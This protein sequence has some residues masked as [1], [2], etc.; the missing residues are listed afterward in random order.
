MLDSSLFPRRLFITVIVAFSLSSSLG[1]GQTC[2]VVPYPTGELAPGRVR[3]APGL[4]FF[5]AIDYNSQ[6]DFYLVSY[7]A[8]EARAL[9]LNS[10]GSV[11]P[12]IL[13]GPNN[14]VQDV[15][16]AYNPDRNE[17]LA[18]WRY[19]SPT[20]L[21]GR[22]L[23]GN[24][25]PLG[26]PFFMGIA[27]ESRIAYNPQNQV[28]LVAYTGIGVGTKYRMVAGD[29]T[30]VN[31]L[32]AE[33]V[34]D[35]TGFSGRVA[36]G[37]AANQ[38]LIVFVKDFAAPTR[39][40]VWGRIVSG[41]GGSIG[42][43]IGIGGGTE[44]Q[45]IPEV[46]YAPT[47]DQF[48]VSFEDWSVGGYPD[49]RFHYVTSGGSV[50]ARHNLSSSGGVWDNPGPITFN[51]STGK[52]VA[53]YFA[54]VYGYFR[55][56]TPGTAQFSPVCYYSYLNAYPLGIAARPDPADPQAAVVFRN[57]YGDDG[58][59]VSIL[60]LPPPPPS[61]SSTVMPDGFFQQ[62]YSQQVPVVGGTHPLSFQ[63]L[64]GSLPP[65][66]SGPN[67]STG[68]VSGTP[69]SMGTFGPFRVRVTDNQARSAEADLTMS[70]KLAAPTALSPNGDIANL[71]PTFTWTAVAGATS[72]NIEVENLTDGGTINIT[73]VIGTS[74]S[75][76]SNLPANKNFRWRAQASNGASV[77]PFSGY[78]SFRTDLTS[79]SGIVLS[80]AVPSTFA[81][82]TG[83]TA[84]ASSGD[85]NSANSKEMAVDG[86]TSTLWSTP[87]RPAL[88]IEF[89]TLD[90]GASKTFSHVRMLSRDVVPELF[91]KDFQ[92]QFSNDNVN[93]TTGATVTNFSTPASTWSNFPL[94]TTQARYLRIWITKPSQY[95]ANNLFYA[96]IVEIE[97]SLA[98]SAAGSI[99]VTWAAPGDDGAT[100]TAASYDLRFQAGTIIDYPNATQA[101]VEPVPAQAGTIQS[102]TLT[103]LASET[104]FAIAIKSIDD[105]GN[106]SPMSNTV[107][108][109]TTG[110][111]PE[112]IANLATN[113]PGLN[114]MGVQWSAP[115]ENG[116]DGG[117]VTG[118]DL[119]YSTSPIS[120]ASFGAA[121]QVTGMPAPLGPGTTQSKTVTGLQ[122]NTRYYFAIESVDDVGNVSAISNI[123][124]GDTLDNIPPGAVSDLT[125]TPG[126]ALFT[127]ILGVAA[128]SSSGDLSV[129]VKERAVDGDL[130]T[131]WSSPPRGVMQNE[132]ITLD[133]GSSQPVGRLRIRSRDDLGELFPVDF[134]IQVSP[135]N[136]NYV[137]ALNVTGY[138]SPAATWNTFTFPSVTGRYVRVFVTKAAAYSNGFFYV[139][140][141]EIEVYRFDLQS[142]GVTLQ[143][144]A[145]GDDGS[146]GTAASYEFRHSPNPILTDTDFA[147]A[148]AVSPA[149]VPAPLVA[150]TIQTLSVMG[151]GTE[152]VLWWAVKTSD[153]RPNFSPL[154]NSVKVATPGTAPAAVTD[155][156]VTGMTTNSIT[157]SWTATGDN[158]TTGTAA[159]YDLR[160][161]TSPIVSL[162]DFNAATQVVVPLPQPPGST[163]VFA[164]IGLANE[165]TY[166]FAVRVIDDAD[167]ASAPSNVVSEKTLDGQAPAS[168]SNLTAAFPVTGLVKRN[169]V[170]VGA[171]G[172]LDVHVK[173]RAVD[174]DL[175]TLWSSPARDVQQVEFLTLDLLTSFSIG[176]VRLRSRSDLGTLFPRDFEI[177]LSADGVAFTTAH[178]V[179]DFVA[180]AATWYTFDFP[181]KTGRFVR[182]LVTETN[183]YPGN[184]KFYA[185]IAEMEAY[186]GGLL[187]DRVNLSWTA[188]GDNGTQGTASAYDIRYKTTA[189]VI[190]DDFD[191]AIEVTG[192]PAPVAPGTLQSMTIMGVPAEATLYF[193]IKTQ[194]EVPIVSD[195]SNVPS[196]V[197]P[198]VTPA[199]VST[200]A[201]GAFTDTN[202]QLNWNATGDDG[203][204]GIANSY[205][206]RYRTS[207]IV[208]QADFAVATQ[209]A[210]EPAPLS[211]G[212]PQSF[213]VTGLSPDTLY[214]FGIKVLDEAGG[215]SPLSNVVSQSTA[216]SSP[217]AAVTNLSATPGGYAYTLRPANAVA[218]SGFLDIH[219]PQRTV[220][221]D[222]ETIW[223]TPG[224]S[225]A[226]QEFIT[227]DLGTV[228]A[229]G[230]VR[231]RSRSDLAS[232][233]PKSFQFQVSMDGVNFTTVDSESNFV[234]SNGTWYGFDFT[235]GSGRYLRLLVTAANAYTNGF[236]YVQLAE[237]EVYSAV[238]LTTQATL[239]WTA[240]GDNGTLGTASS[241]DLRYST[242]PINDEAG[243]DAATPLSGEPAPKTAGSAETFIASGLP[244]ETP[245]YFAL[246]TADDGGN[247][248]GLS[249]VPQVTMPPILPGTV[250][251]LSVGGFFAT[252]VQLTWTATGDDGSIGTASVYD[253]RYRTS[254]IVSDADFAAAIQAADEPAPLS[255]GSL[256]T[257]TVTGLSPDTLYYFALKVQDEVGG[258]SLLSNSVSQKTADNAI[259]A[260]VTN[261]S[262]VPGGYTYT[263][264][265]A[266]A[267]QA[268]G[269]LDVH[270]KGNAVDQNPDTLWSTPGRA[271]MQQEFLTLD[272]GAVLNVG[273]VR[274]RSLIDLG[275][276]FPKSF[277]FQVSADGVN[278]TTVHTVNNF[279]ASAATWYT[280]TFTPAPG[281]YVR[282]L[283]TESQAYSG[284]GWFYVQIAEMEVSQATAIADR[285]T[286]GWT[287]TGDNG[288]TGTAA[289]YDV[290]YR[291]TM[292]ANDADFDAAIPASGE[293]L[294]QPAG[295]TE[296]FVVTGLSPNTT[297]YFALKVTDES[298]NPSLL[299]NVI[300]VTTPVP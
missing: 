224:R 10:D 101:Q 144:T 281:R 67:A 12:E 47:T 19:D 120:S 229:I 66:L 171:S 141:A 284:N 82:L 79:P 203:L 56:V 95:A 273:R 38:F 105:A 271:V 34:V 64:S 108:I 166:Y 196:L 170:A 263:V 65:G 232:L 130:S 291:T 269:E 192:E 75:P 235:P 124:T 246:K 139:Q 156:Q 204:T 209:A 294:P 48:M 172:T 116:P 55:E 52:Y 178:V 241:Y 151:L 252:S 61:F 239:G 288:A 264:R 125:G 298:G 70:V 97:A 85:I 276:L 59:H 205:D 9:G 278:F 42:P 150:G 84:I 96:Q 13:L 114:S 133:L 188:P 86:N 297:Y 128:I 159:A 210:G 157:L 100:G 290:R 272:I 113:S 165:T 143:W 184:G 244:G 195:L 110:I 29:S 279:V 257:F 71:L 274:L 214:Y 73:G 220:D 107:V 40:E 190:D 176:R 11:R 43:V 7:K 293:P 122:P 118:Y 50:S 119:R 270:V 62:P 3:N 26:S 72:Y 57:G 202:V 262:G 218:S 211:P 41:N 154:S 121:T 77:G 54:G 123:A 149:V 242:S 140:I 78:L 147:N 215:T 295:S 23:D 39:A 74:A 126:A 106:V 99:Q 299:S 4:Q 63:L 227:L 249:N 201:A 93:F 152:T 58:V 136:V 213:T 238:D 129:H 76:A 36:Y 69:T 268:S 173:E 90:L 30:A 44:N 46:G 243:F 160:R 31:P 287:A 27:Q 275:S 145:P 237:M 148:T 186:E 117:A 207:P 49:V 112:P 206:I 245:L 8:G 94:A 163:E 45:Q 296:S 180:A 265:G 32:S 189:I 87:A 283:V 21:Y 194:D 18:T 225:V 60:H 37:S 155:L 102:Y 266:S 88:Q 253:A 28:Y 131:L 234:A 221:Q 22:Y 174:L 24:G 104:F 254:P 6:E 169:A 286:L 250:S 16:L 193:A 53:T 142:G 233:F 280:F 236:F 256:Q 2:P 219:V 261:L 217:P 177:Q 33:V 300:S 134:K 161:S 259:P 168:V 197:T 208:S 5:Q 285:I 115:H 1:Y 282:L 231:L 226:Q 289:S 216:D 135:D 267:V 15:A 132:A 199:A 181:P 83:V 212:M 230:R 179:N 91:P 153:E 68:I 103:G 146:T 111:A 35:A 20:H 162:V 51:P 164:V 247:L 255:A 277:Q 137:D 81:P 109:A 240:P 223:S 89:I 17:F 292:I 258:T 182:V 98:G 187:F 248:S 183:P 167:L 260:P 191:S 92:I 200:L 251:N 185:Q 127:R 25:Q 222:L 175:E 14:N 198:P 228:Y 80:G 138:S 158:G